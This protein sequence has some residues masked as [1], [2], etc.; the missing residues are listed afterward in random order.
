MEAVIGVRV[1][2]AA[3]GALALAAC[4]T[5]TESSSEEGESAIVPKRTSSS[6]DDGKKEESPPKLEPQAIDA[7]P[8][9]GATRACTPNEPAVDG[10]SVRAVQSC[11]RVPF[12]DRSRLEWSPCTVLE[13]TAI[14]PV[15]G[16]C[17]TVQCPAAAP[18]PVRCDLTFGGEDG[19]GCVAKASPSALFVKEGD[20]CSGAMVT[21]KVYCSSLAGT[22]DAQTCPIPKPQKI[23][24]ATPN[25]CPR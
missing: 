2:V 8:T 7:C 20:Q 12:G 13:R 21:G 6:D 25:D 16:D 15:S 1:L 4:T 19:R 3:L 23:Y 5:T 14:V 9:Q 11:R 10:I 17:V 24:A 18:N 22:I